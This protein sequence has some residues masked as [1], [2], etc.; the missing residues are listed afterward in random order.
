MN[1]KIK[2][3]K[4]QS[5]WAPDDKGSVPFSQPGRDRGP[6]PEDLHLHIRG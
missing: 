2:T 1:M 6:L 4:I 3:N 5:L